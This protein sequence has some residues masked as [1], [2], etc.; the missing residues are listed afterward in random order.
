[1]G[2]EPKWRRRK[3]ARPA[4]IV[5]AALAAFVENGFAAT[6]LDDIARRAGVSK[7]ALYRYFDTKEDLFRAVARAAVAP[8]LEAL[9]AAADAFDGP[10]EGLLPVLLGRA[11][12]VVGEGHLPAVVRL[13]IAESRAFPDLAQIWHDNVV[14]RGIALVAELVARAQRRG[15][16]GPGDP[17]LLAFAALGPLV[18]G[19]LF[20]EV[21]GAV[22]EP[23]DLGALAEQHARVVLRGVL[24]GPLAPEPRPGG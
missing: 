4:E 22:G 3:A 6:K 10:F 8:G 19:A 17:R 15:E 13:V 11:A 2:A 18:M 7:A 23:L 5:E 21:F 20:R 9:E 14:S 16:V 12:A 1:M 24:A